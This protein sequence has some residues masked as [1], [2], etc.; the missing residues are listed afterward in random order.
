MSEPSSAQRGGLD[1][2]A[3]RDSGA[4]AATPVRTA[5]VARGTLAVV[6]SGPGRTEALDLQKVR[7]PFAGTLESLRVVLGDRVQSGEEIGAVVSQASQ[8]A[9]TGAQVMLREAKTSAERSDAERAI[10][11]AKQNLIETPLRAPRA[12]IV[13]SRGASQGDLLSPGDSIVSIAS[14]SSIVFI[15][16]IAQSDL[17]RIRPGQRARIDAPGR[18]VATGGT[19]HGLLPADT[20]AVSVPVRIDLRTSAVVVPIGLFG[21]AHITVGEHAGVAIVPA[22]AILRD[23]VNGTA[24]VAVIAPDGRAHWV[25]VGVGVQQAN[26]VEIVSPQ[27]SPGSRVIVSGHIGLP[28]GSH[29]RETATDSTTGAPERTASDEP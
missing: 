19:V 11:L 7:A 10:E 29:V 26:A 21:T 13:T 28:D 12:G 4:V 17:A 3:S 22:A 24:R 23:D 25:A 9:L 14:A 15:A 8:A 20:N 1:T 6:V 16:R 18:A 27:V 5:V 2:A